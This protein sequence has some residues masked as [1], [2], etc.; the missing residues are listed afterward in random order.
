M[1]FFGYLFFFPIM[2]VGYKSEKTKTA[3]KKVFMDDTH[4]PI[5]VST[6]QYLCV[7]ISSAMVT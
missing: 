4:L 3:K 1:L 5:P 6:G 7:T 2:E